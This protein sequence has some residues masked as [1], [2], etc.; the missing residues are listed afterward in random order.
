MVQLYIG[1]F[2]PLDSNDW[3]FRR[4]EMKVAEMVH[5]MLLNTNIKP[6]FTFPLIYAR[7]TLPPCHLIGRLG[8]TCLS[9][10]S[11]VSFF[12]LRCGPEVRSPST[13]ILPNRDH[14]GPALFHTSAVDPQI[15]RLRVRSCACKRRYNLC[16]CFWG[17]RFCLTNREARIFKET[18]F[19]MLVVQV[20]GVKSHIVKLN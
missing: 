10:C 7:C 6:H 20:S 16:A 18:L 13:R 4:F 3:K 5:V 1:P 15:Q 9:G 14:S 17:M 11:S 12:Q 8:A 2:C 19:I